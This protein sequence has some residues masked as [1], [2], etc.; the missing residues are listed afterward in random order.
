M[1]FVMYSMAYDNNEYRKEII[2]AVKS[3]VIAPISAK[4]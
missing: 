2:E 4:L 1:N 3:Y